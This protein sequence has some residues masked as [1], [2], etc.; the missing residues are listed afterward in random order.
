MNFSNHGKKATPAVARLIQKSGAPIDYLRLIKLVYLADRKSIID[1]GIPIVGGTYYSMR[2]GPVISEVM[3]F[4]N[5]QNAPRWKETISPRSGD[6]V[7]LCG[8]PDFGALSK[9]E[10]NI[11]D[12]VVAEHHQRTTEELVA[13]CHDHCPE[14]EQVRAGQRKLI[15]VESILKGAKKEVAQ[16]RKVIESANEIEELNEL[17]A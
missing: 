6:E 13:W 14:Y 2:K 16:I 1:R 8:I 11:L 10:L 3:N 17:L 7:R 12:G 5:M 9:S 4:V 15:T